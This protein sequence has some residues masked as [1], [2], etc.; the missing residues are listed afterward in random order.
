MI[1]SSLVEVDWVPVLERHLDRLEVRVHGHVD[2]DDR[3]AHLSP[4]LQ[5]DRHGLVRELHQKPA[6]R[7]RKWLKAAIMKY[8]LGIG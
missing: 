8:T 6:D 1:R 5:L 4:V 2:A 3:A 7:R